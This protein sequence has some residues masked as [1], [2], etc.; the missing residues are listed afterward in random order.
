[1]KIAIVYHSGFGHTEKLAHYVE[2]GA[3]E[4]QNAETFLIGL[5]EKPVNWN[6]LEN[7]DAIIFGSP[8][9]NG[10]VSARFKQF[11]EDSTGPAFVEQKWRNK[12]AAG[13]TNSGAEHGDKLNSLMTMSL[14]AAQHAMIWVN[15]GLLSGK[16]RNDLNGIG[17]WLG[18]MAQSDNASPDVTPKIEDLNTAKYLGH[19]VAEITKQFCN[20]K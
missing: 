20:G 13:F 15:L 18:A 12:I 2:K 1:M 7:V 17:S 14:F 8:T 19:H 6:L 11:M 4:V 9:Y 3:K 10:T 5:D 16:T